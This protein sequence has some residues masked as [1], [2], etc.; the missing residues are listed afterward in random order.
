VLPALQVLA[1]SKS[2]RRLMMGATNITGTVPCELFENHELKT[3]MISIN[4]LEGT[5]PAC[6][7]AVSGGYS[8]FL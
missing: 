5:L 1:P 4:E 6:V 3:L 8:T 2:L 7:L